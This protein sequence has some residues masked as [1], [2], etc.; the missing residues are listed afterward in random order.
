M[1][2]SNIMGYTINDSRV[3]ILLKNKNALT[4][5]NIIKNAQDYGILFWDD[6]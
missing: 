2:L 4:S 3:G 5:N 1:N 6:S